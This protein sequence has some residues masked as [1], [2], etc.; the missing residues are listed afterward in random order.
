MRVAQQRF[1]IFL[2]LPLHCR[3]FRIFDLDPMRRTPRDVTIRLPHRQSHA[4]HLGWS[5]QALGGSAG[6]AEVRS[7]SF[8]TDSFGVRFARWRLENS[9]VHAAFSRFARCCFL[10]ALFNQFR[11][12]LLS[13]CLYW[14][15]LEYSTRRGL[16][17]AI[18]L[19]CA[20]APMPNW[21]YNA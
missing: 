10:Q 7:G 13:A 18:T 19:P 14:M 5:V 17:S 9:F 4:T 21:H 12:H 8:A 3:R 11:R 15:R 20:G 6:W 2:Y 1:P 16:Y